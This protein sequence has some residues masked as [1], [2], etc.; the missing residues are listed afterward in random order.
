MAAQPQCL[1]TKSLSRE[2]ILRFAVCYLQQ[3][4]GYFLSRLQRVSSDMFS[5][6]LNITSLEKSSHAEHPQKPSL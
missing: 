3:G 6:F 5:V 2:L 1:P 4:P